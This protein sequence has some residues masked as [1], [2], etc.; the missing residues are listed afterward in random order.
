M[1]SESMKGVGIVVFVVL[2]VFGVIA[3]NMLKIKTIDVSNV[4]TSKE[5]VEEKFNTGI[6]LAYWAAAFFSL[7]IFLFCSSVLEHLETINYRL[8]KSAQIGKAPE[9]SSNSKLDLSKIK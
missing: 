9:K 6:M 5:I 7:I 1:K 8:E 4:L 3:G 2:L